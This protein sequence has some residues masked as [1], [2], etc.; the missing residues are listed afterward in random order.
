M[1][2]ET[3]GG[4]YP[5]PNHPWWRITTMGD[6]AVVIEEITSV[7]EAED[8]RSFI[9]KRKNWHPGYFPFVMDRIDLTDMNHEIFNALSG[10]GGA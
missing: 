3:E 7:E 10:I 5:P 9:I 1:G 8:L 2:K 6:L 4:F